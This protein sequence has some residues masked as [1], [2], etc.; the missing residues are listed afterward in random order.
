MNSVATEKITTFLAIGV[1]LGPMV[2][3]SQTT[4]SP[5]VVRRGG[6]FVQMPR[7]AYEWW[8][9]ALDGVDLNTLRT[10]ASRQHTL[11]DMEDNLA[12]FVESQLLWPWIAHEPDANRL[13]EIRVIP[14]GIGAGNVGDDPTRFALLSRRDATPAL[15]VDFL[16]YTLWSFCDGAMSLDAACR[17]TS[18]YLH[19]PLETVQK[20]AWSLIPALMRNGLAFLDAVM[21]P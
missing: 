19:T 13:G 4:D 15:W 20:R 1:P 11:A 17:A 3:A 8:H 21:K 2:S 14:S 9:R 10:I 7:F 5:W 6:R 18:E 12:W 16:A